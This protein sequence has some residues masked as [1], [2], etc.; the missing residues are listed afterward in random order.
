MIKSMTGFGKA[1]GE[2]RNKKINIEIRSL[3]SK[4]LDLNTRISGIYREK[5]LQVKAMSG[6]TIIRGKAEVSVYS[7]SIGEI[8][9]LTINQ[10][11][12]INYYKELQVL[13]ENI[14]E[15]QVPL[16]GYILKMPD[17]MKSDKSEAEEEEWEVIFATLENA[18]NHFDE[19]RI[20]EGIKLE[21]ELKLR[22]FNILELLSFILFSSSFT[23]SS[24]VY[25]PKTTFT[26]IS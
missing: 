15:T 12:A 3:N 25:A 21:E 13:A 19:F 17:V 16:I 1:S 23:P 10:E 24:I 26:V 14:G 18:L 6:N 5:E 22:V 20:N 8:P 4:Q 7:E 11:L 9:K 2:F